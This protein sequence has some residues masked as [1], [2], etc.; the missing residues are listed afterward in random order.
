M[1]KHMVEWKSRFEHSLVCPFVF[2]FLRQHPVSRDNGKCFKI[3]IIVQLL[4]IN[5][6]FY[7]ACISWSHIFLSCI[8]VCVCQLTC[9][10]CHVKRVGDGNLLQL[11]RTLWFKRL[12]SSISSI[13]C[14]F[15]FLPIS[16]VYLC[17]LSLW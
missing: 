13:V 5:M 14:R 17:F 11:I 10:Y 9:S 6:E 15:S 3:D 1:K 16:F 7:F 8:W 12:L 4:H 2:S